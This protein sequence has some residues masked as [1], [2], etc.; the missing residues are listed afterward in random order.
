MAKR[1]AAQDKEVAGKTIEKGLLIVHTGKGKGKSTAAFG[2]MLRALGR[3]FRCGV[4]QFGKGAWQSGERAAI[5]KFGDQIE[6]HTL[7]EGFTWETQDRARDVAAAERA[8]DATRKMM[9]NPAIRL[10]VLDE[11]NIALRYDHLDIAEVVA[12]L[13]A[14]RPDQHIVVTGRN[15]KPEMIEAAD[16]VTEMMPV[17]HHFA[18]GVK[19]QE[20]IEF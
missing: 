8:W 11:L 4:V 1:K 7:G 12:V 18:A 14:R 20:G 5:E 9:A 15:A 13:L 6:W 3:G 2:L 19:A 17:K 16:L 10:I